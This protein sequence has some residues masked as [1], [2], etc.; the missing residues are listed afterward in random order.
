MT[1]GNLPRVMHEDVE[2]LETTLPS[3]AIA[4]K[5]RW[6]RAGAGR[7]DRARGPAAEEQLQ[8]GTSSSWVGC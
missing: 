1:P 3:P 2:Q 8:V 5:S 6:A 7:V 4:T